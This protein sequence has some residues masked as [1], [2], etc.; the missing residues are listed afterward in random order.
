MPYDRRVIWRALIA[1]ALL[2]AGC[3]STSRASTAPA[4]APPGAR[5]TASPAAGLTYVMFGDSW[6]YGA[7]CGGCTPFPE[8]LTD[9]FASAA[10]EPVTL[11]NL[12]TDGGTAEELASQMQS[13]PTIQNTIA[14][15]DIIVIAIGAND[16]VPAL[17]SA[18]GG[19]CGGTDGLDCFRAVADKLRTAYDHML[20]EIDT[21]RS[22]RPTAVRMV[23][24]SNEFLG[25]PGLV[26]LLGA[27]FGETT[28]VTV[29]KLD[30]DI[31]CEVA[32]AH[33]AVCVDLGVALNGPDLLTPNDVNQQA[34]MQQVADAILATGLDELHP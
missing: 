19:T 15:G 4:S 16:L 3:G 25:D 27:D 24:T 5:G 9:S 7:H 13:V 6:P 29:T 8:L 23:T 28:G 33:H 30:R 34:T 32:M 12:T 21:L 10:G 20:T 22:G 11:R 1:A 14:G 31:E 2:V 17:E 26:A 18:G